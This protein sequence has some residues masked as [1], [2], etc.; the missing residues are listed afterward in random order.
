MHTGLYVGQDC[1]II[2][3]DRANAGRLLAIGPLELLW[4]GIARIQ[5]ENRQ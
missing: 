4:H 2:G 5:Q 1:A 3:K